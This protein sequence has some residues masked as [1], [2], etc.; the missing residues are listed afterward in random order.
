MYL[1]GLPV[2]PSVWTAV[3]AVGVDVQGGWGGR[4]MTGVLGLDEVDESRGYRLSILNS[5]EI[6]LP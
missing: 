3:A 5:D 1:P 6:I 4:R 2:Q